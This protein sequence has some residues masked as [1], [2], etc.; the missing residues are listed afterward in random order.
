MGVYIGLNVE[1]IMQTCRGWIPIKNNCHCNPLENLIC[2]WCVPPNSTSSCVVHCC[3]GKMTH[4]SLV[5]QLCW[6]HITES[7]TQLVCCDQTQFSFLSFS[8]AEDFNLARGDKW[9]HEPRERLSTTGLD[10]AD[11][12]VLMWNMKNNAPPTTLSA[13]LFVVADNNKKN[14]I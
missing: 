7:P 8:G 3:L 14:L 5:S 10:T 12:C 13:D 2:K 6:S 9:F 1:Y 11:I 4:G